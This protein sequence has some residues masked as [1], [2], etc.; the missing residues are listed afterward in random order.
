M[1][2]IIVLNS[3]HIKIAPLSG[4]HMEFLLGKNQELSGCDIAEL[5][6]AI[7]ILLLT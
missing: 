2:E 4:A 6:H 3:Y 1:H 7:S 5:A